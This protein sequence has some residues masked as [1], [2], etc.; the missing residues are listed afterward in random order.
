MDKIEIRAV[1]RYL[2][3]EGTT[4]SEVHD[5]ML[6][7]LAKSAT[8]FATATRWIRQFIK[9]GRDGVEDGPS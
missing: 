7:T 4:A 6:R 8:S 2:H 9:C 5:D 3:L 1:I